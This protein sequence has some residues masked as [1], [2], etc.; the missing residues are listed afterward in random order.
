MKKFTINNEILMAQNCEKNLLS[1]NLRF[2]L[3]S[4]NCV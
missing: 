4:K 3:L 2:C 1:T